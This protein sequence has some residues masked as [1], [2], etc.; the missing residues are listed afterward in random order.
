[1]Q[2]LEVILEVLLKHDM[3]VNKKRKLIDW[4]FCSTR[5]STWYSRW[6]FLRML[7]TPYRR[8]QSL[9]KVLPLDHKL[10]L[11]QKAVQDCKINDVHH[12][13]F[14]WEILLVVA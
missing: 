1:V 7:Y 9:P 2:Q 8:P 4:N 5:K 13:R 14:S 12:R 6:H 11:F 10:K 3:R